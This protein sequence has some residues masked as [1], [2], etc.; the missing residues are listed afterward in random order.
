MGLPLA[1]FAF[2][3]A[4]LPGAV[5]MFMACN[6]VYFSAGVKILDSGRP[7][8]AR[9]VL[10]FLFSPMML[11]MIAGLAFAGLHLSLPLV[12]F[13]ALK[14]LGD[15]AI[16]LMLFSL[17]V[18]M[19]DLNLRSW[20]IGVIAAAACPLFGMAIAWLL[21]SAFLFS[22]IEHAQMYLFASLP[23]AVFCFVMAERYGQEPDKVAAIV[24]L[25]NLAS[26]LF[27]PLGLWIGLR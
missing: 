11:A 26:I 5:A 1:V 20:H 9:L 23:P 13:Q 18:R 8:Q 2:G 22:P 15:A 6:L 27:V 16:P 3:P 25:G 17:G 10:D 14:M 4:G 21:E 7:G 12:L 24:M 19:L